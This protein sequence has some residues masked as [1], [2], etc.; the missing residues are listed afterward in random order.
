MA[1]DQLRIL[2]T[3]RLDDPALVLGFGGWMDGGEVSTG[4]VR[5]LVEQFGAEVIGRIEP[6]DFYIF[7]FPGPMEVASL[8]RPSGKISGGLIT[9]FELPA[10]TF[11]CAAGRNLVLFEGQEPNLRWREY[12]DCIFALAEALGV[13]TIYF[14][15]SVSGLV[16]HTREPRIF[17]AVSEEGLKSAL[18]VS[19]VRFSDYE[20]PMS[21]ITYLMVLA[22]QHGL[23]V[24]TLVAE[25][26]AYVQ[27]HNP[28]GI[29]ATIRKLTTIMDQ[30]VELDALRAVSDEWEKRVT[31]VVHQREDLAKYID[32]LETDYDHEVFDTQMGDLK[33]WLEQRGIRLD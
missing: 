15:G 12:A 29:A 23:R 13:G 21:L 1:A 18:E 6:D 25:I 16:T 19:G 22:P 9:A 27:G 31:E 17:S 20:G 2:A 10:N 33:T 24:I 11:Y 26:P 28:K 5:W 8:F 32:K 4:T 7:N 3:P 14:V 30:P